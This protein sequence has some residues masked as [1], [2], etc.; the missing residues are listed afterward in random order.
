MLSIIIPTLNEEKYLPK[1]LESLIGQNYNDFEIIVA[2]GSSDDRTREI[3]Q[4]A[5]CRIT[6]E[7][8]RHP[9][10]ERNAGARI[11]H[12]ELLLFL[13]ADTIIPSNDFLQTIINEFENRKLDVAGFYLT[14]PSRH[15]F[16]LIYQPVYNFL[17]FLAQYIKPLAT[18]GGGMMVRK[19]MHDKINGFDETI[20]IGEDHDYAERIAKLG[21][22]RNFKSCQTGFSIR[23][24]DKEG[25]LVLLGKWVYGL[26]YVLFKGPIRKQIIKYDFGKF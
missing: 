5:G 11:A 3:A 4:A 26:L 8:R 1:L 23:R 25:K 19:S 10:Y 13:D 22:F 12:G 9:S 16:F 21:K 15:L 24:I 6:V 14:F 2:D 17:T 18:G 7:N 20:F